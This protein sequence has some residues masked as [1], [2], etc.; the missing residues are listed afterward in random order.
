MD[1]KRRVL[2]TGA[3]SA[4]LVAGSSAFA[5]A[6]GIF[7]TQPVDRVGTFQAIQARLVPHT[8]RVATTPKSASGARWTSPGSGRA[9][10]ST[11]GIELATT[12]GRA[13]ETTTESVA[14]PTPLPASAPTYA[15]TV[16]P[17][18]STTVAHSGPST[19][20]TTRDDAPETSRPGTTRPGTTGS[21][22][23]DD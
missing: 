17:T 3:L 14:Q 6:N 8:E 2:A 10:T 7:G 15:P 5:F 18:A 11:S 19:V 4:V 12:T 20:P 16:A 1:R 23:S 13:N 9:T 21:G 22:P